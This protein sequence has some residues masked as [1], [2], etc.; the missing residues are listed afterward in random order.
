MRVLLDKNAVL[1]KYA[2][3]LPPVFQLHYKT[4]PARMSGISVVSGELEKV[5]AAYTKQSS[6]IIANNKKF[7]EIELDSPVCHFNITLKD[8]NCKGVIE[9]M[10]PVAYETH[11][12]KTELGFFERIS[13][14][15][16]THY[17]AKFWA[18]STNFF[19]IISR[20][21]KV[22]SPE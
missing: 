7:C 21:S 22:I 19:T 4:T 20:K 13:S 14:Q 5:M 9:E 3:F 12:R 15:N 17:S 11:K 6:S 1:A 16:K 2:F 10:G 8:K 18:S